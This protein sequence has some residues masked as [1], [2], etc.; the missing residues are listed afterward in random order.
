MSRRLDSAA[1]T[2]EPWRIHGIAPE[3]EL[4]DVWALPTP[5]GPDDFPLLKQRFLNGDLANNP[6]RIARTL[7]AIRWRLGE[8]LGWDDPST[9][10]GSRVRSLRDRLPLD[11]AQDQTP[12]PARL[13]FTSLYATDSEWAAEMANRTVHA[14]M[15]IGWVRDEACPGGH[16][17]QMAVLV[18]PNGGWGRAYMTAI[19]PFRHGL[20]YPPMMR[21]I[22]AG[23][24]ERTAPEVKIEHS[25]THERTEDYSPVHALG[26]AYADTLTM[27]AGSGLPARWWV[28]TMFEELIHPVGRETLF[29]GVLGLLPAHKPP[30]LI[31]WEVVEESFELLRL[32][33][34]G[35]LMAC[36]L[37]CGSDSNSVWLGLS[38]EPRNRLGATIWSKVAPIHRKLGRKLLHRAWQLSP[39][40]KAP[41]QTHRRDET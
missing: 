29:R 13:P 24:L 40:A 30:T 12:D 2:N 3:F 14:V 38:V 35:P 34:S 26:A 23:W 1:H 18:K 10:A 15:H 33:R 4:Y 25:W 16:R 36:H 41:D 28:N 6:S 27:S 19:G 5:G 7:F 20:V 8:W 11:L 39:E 9:S 37:R 32:E 31:G 21:G 22:A 17:G